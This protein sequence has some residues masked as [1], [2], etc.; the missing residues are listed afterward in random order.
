MEKWIE[1]IDSN[2]NKLYGK[3]VIRDTR[4]PVDLVLEKL[5]TGDSIA[6][7]L[8]AYPQLTKEKIQACL[9]FASDTIKNEV[10]L[11]IAG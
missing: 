10:I 8:E 6:D 11:A 5:A 3:P 9:L 7:I 2:P 4:I 1:Y